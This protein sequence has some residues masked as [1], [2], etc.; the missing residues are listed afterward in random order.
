M[1]PQGLSIDSGNILLIA[2]CFEQVNAQTAEQTPQTVS[3]WE[4][5]A[6]LTAASRMS[7]AGRKSFSS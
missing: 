6:L 7:T 2:Q 1:I 5:V 4:K 3:S